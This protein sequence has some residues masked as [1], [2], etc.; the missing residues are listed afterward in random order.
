[1]GSKDIHFQKYGTAMVDM[2]SCWMDSFPWW[3][4]FVTRDRLIKTAWM[5]RSAADGF[6]G[7]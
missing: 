2:T 4:Q 6:S 1:M 5:D 7:A 3:R